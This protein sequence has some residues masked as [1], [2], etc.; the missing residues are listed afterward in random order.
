VVPHLPRDPPAG[1]KASLRE[2]DGAG[3][4]DTEMVAN[5]IDSGAAVLTFTA[6]RG[7]P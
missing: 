4:R 3:R 5:A 2:V 6:D 1:V 7:P